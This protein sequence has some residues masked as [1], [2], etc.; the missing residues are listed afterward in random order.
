MQTYDPAKYTITVLGNVLVQF[1]TG[2]FIKA[3]RNEDGYKI[4][5][6]ARGEGVRIKNNNKSGRFEVTLL[7]SSPSNAILAA[8][9]VADELT[10]DQV[11]P[12]MV[13]DNGGTAFAHAEESWIVK[14]ADLE[15]GDDEDNIT[16]IIETLNIEIQPDGTADTPVVGG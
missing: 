16:W 10:N 4:K 15:R 7:R 9:A 3:M 12:T 2:T 14:L 5:V 8:L 11:G 13:K 1:G 6:G